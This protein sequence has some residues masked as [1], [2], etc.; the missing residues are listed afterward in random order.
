MVANCH[1]DE[2]FLASVREKGEYLAARLEALK[3]KHPCLVEVRGRGLIWGLE[4]TV[5]AEGLIARGY[6]EG[7]IVC[8]AGEK[9]LRLLPPLVVEKEHL[10]LAV[11]KL[12][13][14]LAQV[15][16]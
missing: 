7:L 1:R 11:E 3:E 13:S 14:L 2:G 8:S 4:L 12:G 10:D 15:Q 16:E 6:E 9:V 5:K